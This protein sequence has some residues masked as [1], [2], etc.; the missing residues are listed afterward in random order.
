MKR[1][2]VLI[3]RLMLFLWML[4]RAAGALAEGEDSNTIFRIGAFDRSSAEFTG[5]DPEQPVN[6]Q[7]GKSDPAKDWYATQPAVSMTTVAAGAI[8][9]PTGPRRITFSLDR[10][11][12]GTCRFHVSFLIESASVPALRI[13][14]NGKHG[15]FYLQPQLDYSNGDQ[16]DS[17]YPASSQA[18]VVFDFPG[19]YL[20]RGENTIAM[21]AVEEVD[22]FVPQ[23]SLTYDAIE[24]KSVPKGLQ[25][26]DSS[27]QIRPTIFYQ[28][29]QGQLNEVVEVLIRSSKRFESGGVDLTIAGKRYHQALHGAQDFGEGKLEFSVPQFPM[30]TRVQLTWNVDGRRRHSEQFID[31]EKQWTLFLVPH[32]HLDVGYSDYQAKVATIQSRVIDEAMDM[33]AQHPDF[34]FSLDGEWDLAEFMKARTPIEQQRVIAAIQKQQL[35]VPAQYA[36]LLTGFPTAETLIRSLYAS[37]NFSRQHCT[38]FNYAN[39]TDVPSYSWSY[40]SILASA[41]IHT[42]LSASNNYR[43]PVLLQGHLNESSP[44]WWE[45]PDGQKVLFWY[46][47]HYEQMEMLFGLPPLLSA[48]HDTLPLFLQMYSHANYHANAAILYG[49]QEENTDLF[50]QQAELVG[51]W[52]RVYAYPKLQYSG[53]FDALNNIAQ[54]FGDAIPTIRGDGGPYWEDGI[55]SDAFY[56]AM[57]R[58]NESRGLSA[59]KLATVASLVNPRLAADKADLDAMWNNMVLMDE[60]TWDSYNSISEPLGMEAVRQLAV[61][62]A[63]AAKAQ[64]LADFVARSSM[65]SLADSISAGRKS[66][67]V[68]N[69]LNWT[70]SAPVELDLDTD[71]EIADVTTEHAVP[72]EIIRD[73]KDV[74]HVSFMARDVPAFGYKVFQSRPATKPIVAAENGAAAEIESPYYR[75]QLDPATGAVRGIYDKQLERELVNQQS[76]YRFG[77]YLYVTGGDQGPNR[78]LQY[79]RVYPQPQLQI[80]PAKGVHPAAVTRTPEG[81]VARMQSA[82][83]NTPKV[84]SEVRL[85]DHE[86]KIEFVEDVEK[87]EVDAKEAVYFA[88]PF[89]MDRPQFRY[90]IQTGVVDPANNMYPGAGHEWFSVQHWVSVQQEDVSATVMPLDVPLVTLGDINRGAWP[91]EFGPRPANIFSYVMNNYWDTNYRAG[92]GGT[93]R[94]R[95]VVTSAPLTNA[96]ELSRLGWAEMTPFE[97]DEVTSQ[98]KALNGPRPLNGKQGAFLKIE[99]ADLLVEDWKPAEDGNGTIVRLLDL[100]GSTRTATVQI[101]LLQLTRVFRTDAVERDQEP[102]PLSGPSSFPI[103]VRAHEIVTVRVMGTGT[104]H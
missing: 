63:Y 11:V 2:N 9:P 84:V 42:L 76:P 104:E 43:A 21:Q 40:A 4:C 24:L 60:H 3:F 15:V 53:F 32:I 22:K 41:G 31:P 66:V 28:E 92:Q 86:K 62:D 90:E 61:K 89:A 47:R 38:P 94:F 79:S 87:E 35:F 36:N 88:F 52:N 33:T 58:Q 69:T 25:S 37:A 27:A 20:R 102:I 48:G 96:A 77:Q 30:K 54:Q 46:S 82:A 65:A 56:A 64:E 72:V 17:F 13:E 51:Q 80:H 85:F 73:G 18:D 1:Q 83:T 55:A 99:D 67:I 8:P 45:G 50:P 12:S 81:W 10:A 57:E 23:A 39:I 34:R 68:F 70:R 29:A 16:G 103:K 95:Y 71:D 98:D 6:F 97:S 59:E 19:E 26:K 74:R 101:P 78:V 75:V 93:F 7:V 44:M 49:T 14:I 100:G 5:G 91:T